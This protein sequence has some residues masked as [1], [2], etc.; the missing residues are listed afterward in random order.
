MSEVIG[1]REDVKRFTYELPPSRIAERPVKPADAAKFLCISK[2]TGNI[3]HRIFADLDKIVRPGDVMVLNETKVQ[4]ARLFGVTATGADVEVL[5]VNRNRRRAVVMA[6]PLK[7][8]KEGGKVVF[9][10][11]LVA[12][13]GK[14][15]GEF[16]VE[17]FFE[18]DDPQ[19]S[20]LLERAGTM[21]IPPYIRDGISDAEDLIDYQT[22]FANVPGSIAAPTAS[23]HFTSEL[24]QRLVDLGV[25][26]ERLVLHLGVASFRPISG[27]QAPA[28]EQLIIS[29]AQISRLQEYKRHQQRIIA[30]GTSATRALESALRPEVKKSREGGIFTELFITPGFNF[31]FVDG[32]ITNFHQPDTTHLLLVEAILGRRNI[33]RAY[34]SALNNGYRF[35]SYG[36]AMFVVPE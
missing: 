11:S 10:D 1:G 17:L 15:E 19:L 16:C 22:I 5:I 24:M 29:D 2:S 33:E 34:D 36:D 20:E 26:F 8:F 12:L 30:V 6:R 9:N 7:R 18:A 21:P 25:I 32:L 13:V 31:Q 14:R 4:P 3:D 23:L 35:L 27:E 28:A